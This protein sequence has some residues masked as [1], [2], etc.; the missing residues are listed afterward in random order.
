MDKELKREL[1]IVR[2]NQ[3]AMMKNM[4]LNNEILKNVLLNMEELIRLQRVDDE[5]WGQK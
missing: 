5:I 3:S 1:D 2:E 4:T